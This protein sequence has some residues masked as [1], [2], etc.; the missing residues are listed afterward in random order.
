MKYRLI[1]SDIDGTLTEVWDQVNDKN[2]DVLKKL[3]A[4]GVTFM[5]ATGRSFRSAEPILKSLDIPCYACLVNGAILI[6]YPD[7][8]LIHTNYLSVKNKNLIVEKIQSANGHIIMFNGFEGGDKLYYTEKYYLNPVLNKIVD[9]Y[10]EDRLLLVE[11]MIKN[12]D[13]SVPVIS[14]IGTEEEIDE[15]LILL[16]PYHDEFNIL[17]LRETYVQG[18]FWLMITQKT[19]DKVHGIQYISNMLKVEQQEIIA[20]GDDLNDLEMIKYAGL[21][22]AM[23]NG[24]DELK[25]VADMIAPSCGEDGLAQVIEELYF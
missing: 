12:I 3:V 13:H 7:L 18:Y 4:Q 21:G 9:S 19:A 15:I 1:A 8:K 17:K 24:V 16:E 14:C 20:I 22:I 2:R 25:V 11:D 5:I 10:E 6:S 23:G